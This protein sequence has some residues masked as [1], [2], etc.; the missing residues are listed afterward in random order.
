MEPAAEESAPSTGRALWISVGAVLA[1]LA[2]VAL[3]FMITFSNRAR[4]EALGWERRTYEVMLL[5][6][7]I[8]AAIARSE[9]A[10]GRYVLDENDV[11]GTQ[12]VN[13]WRSAAWQVG[14][15]QR[16][17]RDD[18]EQTRRTTELRALLAAPRR[19]ARPRRDR[20]PAGRGLGRPQRPLR[21]E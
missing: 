10:L 4:D 21:R 17:V 8:D 2:L 5:S 7:N 3:I 18:A 1:T 11:T 20:R 15:L 12:Y 6:R 19:R 16:Q 14:Q 9:A 13:E